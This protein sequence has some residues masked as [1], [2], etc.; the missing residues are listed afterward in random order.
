MYIGLDIALDWCGGDT[1][2]NYVEGYGDAYFDVTNWD[3]LAALIDENGLI[4][5]TDEN[6]ALFVPVTT[7]NPAWGETENDIPNYLIQA[8]S[9]ADGYDFSNVGLFKSG[10]NEI[11]YVFNNALF[12]FYLKIYALT[13][14]WLVE[15]TLYDKCL[16][17]TESA[18]GSVWSSTYNTSVATSRSYGPYKVSDYQLDKSIHFVKNEKWYGWTEGN[19]VYVDPEDGELYPMYQSTEIDCQ[20]VAESQTR[21]Q[22]FL[23][24]ELMGYGL[25]AEDFDQYRNSEFAH[26]TPAE[27]V[28]F[29]IF[30]GYESVINDREAAAD[31]DQA[32]MDLQSMTLNSFRR[33][34]AV[35]FDKDLFCA[36]VSPARVAAFGLIGNTYIYDPETCAYYRDTPQAM[37]ALCDF[38]SI[39]TSKFA[40]LKDAVASITGYDP[41]TAKALYQQAYEDD[42]NL[43]MFQI[44]DFLLALN[45]F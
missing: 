22:M 7:G 38:Y 27:T 19:H 10:E 36:T 45:L 37:Q 25:Q 39:D 5:L 1:L 8:H 28:Y 43:T 32:T 20:V 35:T 33:A 26:A 14:N 2:K 30:N 31:F 6:Y 23:A 9:Y 41:E 21:K 15:P 34:V 12:G 4:P 18:S 3:A 42:D 16:T 44:E 40:S 11:T 17:E 24:G 29:A 13:C